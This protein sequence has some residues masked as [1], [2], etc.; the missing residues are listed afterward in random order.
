MTQ[1]HAPQAETYRRMKKATKNKWGA[2]VPAT[3]C[4]WMHYLADICLCQKLPA[5]CSSEDKHELRNFRKRALGYSCCS[6][7]L[8]D[9]FFSAEFLVAE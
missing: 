5:G 3:N 9:E 1:A 4:L 2:F 6:E 7:L 8:W